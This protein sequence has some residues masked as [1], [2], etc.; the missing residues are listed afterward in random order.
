MYDILIDFNIWLINTITN[1]QF[2]SLHSVLYVTQRWHNK[3]NNTQYIN[4]QVYTTE[5]LI[6]SCE[7]SIKN[8]LSVCMYTHTHTHTNHTLTHIHVHLYMHRHIKVHVKHA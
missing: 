5:C 6:I 7:S 1:S 3:I 4:R 2:Y 8:L